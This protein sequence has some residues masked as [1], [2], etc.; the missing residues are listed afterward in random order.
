MYRTISYSHNIKAIPGI[1]GQGSKDTAF[2]FVELYILSSLRPDNDIYP[3]YI[4]HVLTIVTPGI[5]D[6]SYPW[7][8][9]SQRPALSIFFIKEIFLMP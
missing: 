6:S 9:R 1:G 8:N 4:G 2:Y 7:D 3:Q 5:I